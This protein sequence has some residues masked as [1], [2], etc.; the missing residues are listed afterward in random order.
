[1]HREPERNCAWMNF[2]VHHWDSQIK[3]LGSCGK[4]LGK[5]ASR[6]W[7]SMERLVEIYCE[8]ICRGGYEEEPA[9][10]RDE[11]QELHDAIAEINGE[12]KY[13]PACEFVKS[14]PMLRPLAM[15]S[16]KRYNGII[17]LP[18]GYLNGRWETQFETEFMA[19]DALRLGYFDHDERENVTFKHKERSVEDE[20]FEPTHHIVDNRFCCCLGNSKSDYRFHCDPRK[21]LEAFVIEYQEYPLLGKTKIVDVEALKETV[22]RTLPFAK[23]IYAEYRG[24]KLRTDNEAENVFRK[25]EGRWFLRFRGSEF[26][27]DDLDGMTYL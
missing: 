16:D 17:P 5:N 14:I 21:I 22:L 11:Q 20:F 18:T 26:R 15:T 3:Y 4:S 8:T 1:M 10:W 12:G 13:C 27:I 9:L 25:E 24:E 7:Q 23:T 19:Q 2:N 6:I